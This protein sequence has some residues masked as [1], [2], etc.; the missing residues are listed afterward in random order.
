MIGS[1]SLWNFSEDKKTGEVGYDLSTKH[2][3]TGV[4]SE[5]LKC[6]LNYGF[7]TLQLDK[8]EAFTHRDNEPS[9]KLLIK[10]NFNLIEHR[11]DVGNL[12]NIIFE[13]IN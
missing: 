8:I 4:M 13:L 2:H 12:N 11:K 5:A 1:I 7:N 10:H 9:K 3:N 6:V